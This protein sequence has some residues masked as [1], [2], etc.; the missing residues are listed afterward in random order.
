MIALTFL[1]GVVVIGTRTS[2]IAAVDLRVTMRKRASTYPAMTLLSPTQVRGRYLIVLMTT[3][4]LFRSTLMRRRTLVTF[5]E[6]AVGTV[7]MT[8]GLT[9]ITAT[10]YITGVFVRGVGITSG[11]MVITWVGMIYG[12][13]SGTTYG[14]TV[15]LDGTVVGMIYGTTVGAV[16]TVSGIGAA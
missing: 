11:D 1:L 6:R 4:I 8:S 13:T 12:P 9:V 10:A 14:T 2:I 7:I 16:G 15:T 3:S 5:V